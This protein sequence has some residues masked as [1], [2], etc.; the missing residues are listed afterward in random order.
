MELFRQPECGVT[1]K[2]KYASA[3]LIPWDP[4][5][6]S[7]CA[8]L[9][10]QRV[11][12]SWDQ[13]LVGEWRGKVREGNKFLYWIKINDNVPAKEEFLAKHLARYPNEKEPIVDTAE[14]LSKS[15]RTPTSVSF[16]PIGHV[17]LDLY[18]DRNEQFS[19]P[20]STVWIKSLYISWAIQAGGFGRSAMHQLERLAAL[21]PLSA[22]AMAL[23]TVTKRFQTTP[24]S[25]AI[26]AKVLGAE[27]PVEQFRSTEEWYARQGYAVVGYV[28]GMYKWLDREMG[29]EV[30]AVFMK[31]DI[32]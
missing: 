7:H 6:E 13:G 23:D 12:C 24:E 22:T 14:S 18:P 26:Y 3:D 21:P 30:P 1:E 17:A 25:L 5:N 16:I 11:A 8:R 2:I 32:V 19:L 20:R 9:F 15:P 4:E 10:E 29:I 31:K 27:L 28:A